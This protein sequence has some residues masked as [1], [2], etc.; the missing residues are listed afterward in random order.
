MK[1]ATMA[2]RLP[3]N[4]TGYIVQ[5]APDSCQN[6]KNR[7]HGTSDLFG[8][9]LLACSKACLNPKDP[10]FCDTVSP[11]GKCDLYE[12]GDPESYS[13]MF[14][15]IPFGEGRK[16]PTIRVERPDRGQKTLGSEPA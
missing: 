4:V 9:R 2:D 16:L 3:R 12:K 5:P 7:Y 14:R 11:L 6:C 15:R 10:S 13:T 8:Q 1:N